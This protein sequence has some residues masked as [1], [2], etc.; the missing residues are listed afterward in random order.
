MGRRLEMRASANVVV[1]RLTRVQSVP[2]DER[3]RAGCKFDPLT[4]TSPRAN[5][6]PFQGTMPVTSKAPGRVAGADHRRLAQ[7]PLAGAETVGVPEGELDGVWL[8]GECD[9]LLLVEGATAVLRRPT[10]TKA[11]TATVATAATVRAE[12]ATNEKRRAQPCLLYTSDAADD[13]TRVDLGG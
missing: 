8:A 5:K 10:T 3:H 9:G 7:G 12:V 4:C 2:S 1:S 11:T 13:L 6:S